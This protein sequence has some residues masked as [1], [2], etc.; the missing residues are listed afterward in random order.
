MDLLVLPDGTVRA[1][2]AEDIDLDVLGRPVITRASHVEPDEQGRWIADL[3]PVA[4]PGSRAVRS[5]QR[6]SRRPS[7][8]GWKPTG[9]PRQR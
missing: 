3:T 8:P 2:Y 9:S 1:I 4:R 5:P 6:G 7:R